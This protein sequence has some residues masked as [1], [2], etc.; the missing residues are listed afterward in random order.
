MKYK[1][2][3]NIGKTLYNTVKERGKIRMKE[4][5]TTT[6]LMKKLG[7]TKTTIHNWINRGLPVLRKTPENNLRAINH[8]DLKTVEKWLE[9]QRKK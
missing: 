7:V 5:L 9:K 8:F 3:D 4:I 2:I 6:E 1:N